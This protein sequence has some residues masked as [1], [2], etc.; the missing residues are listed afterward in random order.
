[1]TSCE[2]A[3]VCCWRTAVPDSVV[4]LA[5]RS[6]SR[7][8]RLFQYLGTTLILFAVAFQVRFFLVPLFPHS[9]IAGL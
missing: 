4:L 1:M 2:C 7:N 8:L 9:S 3:L 6:A 5:V